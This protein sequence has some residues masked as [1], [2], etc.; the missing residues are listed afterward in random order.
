[1]ANSVSG[2][3]RP[4]ALV[5]LRL[6]TNSDLIAVTSPLSPGPVGLPARPR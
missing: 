2:M 3:V 1:V 6:M 4:S 5:V